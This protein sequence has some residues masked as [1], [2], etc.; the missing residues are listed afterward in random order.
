[1]PFLAP[2]QPLRT[3]FLPGSG[4]IR[5]TNDSLQK[6]FTNITLAWQLL[7]NGFVRQKGTVP[8]LS[9]PPGHPRTLHLLLAPPAPGEETWLKLQYRKTSPL[10]TQFL[11]LTPWRGDIRI[12]P[13]GELSFADSNNLFTVSSPTL[14]LSFDKE[15][16]WIQ[17]YTVKDQTLL[18]DSNGLR[19]TLPSPPHL[20]LFSTST[21][22]QMVIVR[23]EYTVPGLSCLLHLSYTVNANGAL[24]I[25][26]TLETDT[27]RSDSIV[28]PIVRFGVNWTLGSAADSL[29]WY[30][31][32][33][34][35][36]DSNPSA[37]TDSIPS[38]H[39]AS[40]TTAPAAKN[41]RWCEFY[42][43]AGKGFRL[44]ADSNFLQIHIDTAHKIV[45]IDNKPPPHPSLPVYFH[46]SFKATPLT[47]DRGYRAAK[48]F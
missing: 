10:S 34:S 17:Q 15:S 21:G 5:I 9:L 44:T 20:Q 16:G 18:A 30:G 13:T 28:H 7:S 24:L 2:G 48:P 41:I 37:A 47:F 4:S 31:F 19:P 35:A 45:E 33:D 43:H 29:A 38:I 23:T 26:E 40:L 36:R 46:Y 8:A 22:S 6:N 1:M 3:T 39:N 11:P 27:T 32:A 12:P 42:D 14:R 25:E